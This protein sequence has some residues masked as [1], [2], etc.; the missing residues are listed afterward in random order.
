MASPLSPTDHDTIAGVIFP[1]LP[2]HV[3]RFFDCRKRVFVKYVGREALPTKLKLGS[4]LFFYQSRSNK[5]IVGEARIVDMTI[6]TAEEVT[7][8]YPDDLFLTAEELEDYVGNRKNKR[9]LVLVLKDIRKY[10]TPIRLDKGPAMSGRYMTK[11]AL[12]S[13]RATQ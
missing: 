4:K 7:R 8:K 1:I 5:C 12:E 3:A 6:D 9:M 2:E 10:A 13:L 11:A